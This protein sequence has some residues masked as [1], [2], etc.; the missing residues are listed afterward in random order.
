LAN[1][2]FRYDVSKA[3]SK[4]RNRILD[5]SSI[6]FLSGSSL[7][8]N[9]GAIVNIVSPI[10]HN[11]TASGEVSIGDYTFPTS[12]GN[13]DDVLTTDG[14]GQLS[15]S[16]ISDL[17]VPSFLVFGQEADLTDQTSFFEL[18]TTNGAQ[19]GQGW[20]LPVSGTVT[21]ISLQADCNS[22]GGTPRTVRVRLFKNGATTGKDLDIV[23]SATGDFGGSVAIVGESFA[24]NDRLTTQIAHSG[25]GLTTGD[26]AIIIRILTAT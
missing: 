17:N 22:Y 23:V 8:A 26:H 18:K 20:R 4:S 12:D 1:K 19:N 7:T 24:A 11:L 15:F 6:T 13:A 5:K 21:H 16:P 10:I 3:V 2:K 25:T 9:S 14:N